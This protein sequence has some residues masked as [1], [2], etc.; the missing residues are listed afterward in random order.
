MDFSKPFHLLLQEGYL[1]RSCLATGLTEFRAANIHNRGAFYSALFN[2]SI[3]LER[4]L[5]SCII[6][7]HMLSNNLETPSI[8]QL[9]SYGHNLSE[10]YSSVCTISNKHAT[11][12]PQ[13]STYSKPTQDIYTLIDNFAQSSRYYNLDALSD[14]SKGLDPLDHINKILLSILS[15]DV[16]ERQIRKSLS[17]GACMTEL[18]EDK[19]SAIITGLDQKWLSMEEVFTLPNLYESATKHAVYRVIQFLDPLRKLISELS[20]HAYSAESGSPPFPQMQEFLEWLWNDRAHILRKK[21]W[22]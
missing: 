15:T 12:I 17:Q 14:S 16:T 11:S 8:K 5:K 21:R 7:D 3:G 1:F 4:L 2:L 19:F 6:M 20:H 9:K 10:L 18:L 22:P 13:L